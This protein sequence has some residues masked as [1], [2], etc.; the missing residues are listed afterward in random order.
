M[1]KLVSVIIPTH[2]YARF[3]TRAVDSVLAQT[4]RGVE[5]IVVDD[6]ST[7]E[8]PQVLSRYGDRIQVIRKDKQG[9]AVARNAGIRASRGQYIALL[10]AD[11][12]WRPDKLA[13]QVAAL[14]A[15][16]SVGAVGCAVTF[17]D[18]E[19]REIGEKVFPT[20]PVPGDLPAQLRGV[21]VRSLW[22]GGSCSGVLIRRGVF[23]DVGLF[24]ETLT[25]AEDWDM[26]VRLAARHEFRNLPDALVWISLHGTGFARNVEK[27]ER[28]QWR[29]YETAVERWPELLDGRTRKRMRALIHADAGGEYVGGRNYRMALRRYAASLWEWPA[30]TGR[31]GTAARLVLRQVGI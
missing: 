31:W 23:D 15:D 20:P 3:V 30:H 10:D 27:V 5:C 12:R 13:R 18:G 28:N 21:A 11:D 4:H 8:T 17:V 1:S 19:G 22:L 2:N 16:A 14:E 6:G 29:V 25:A 26:W 24:D 7:D 9:P